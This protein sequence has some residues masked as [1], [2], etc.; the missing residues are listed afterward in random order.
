MVKKVI[1][2]IFFL[3]P[4]LFL[5]S[6]SLQCF[7]HWRW[8]NLLYKQKKLCTFFFV[9]LK[10]KKKKGTRAFS[11]SNFTDSML[12]ADMAVAGS[13]GAPRSRSSC[14][15]SALLSSN[16]HFITFGC[17][18]ISKLWIYLRTEYER[19]GEFSR[20][21]FID[22]WN[23]TNIFCEKILEEIVGQGMKRGTP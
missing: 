9:Y 1:N 22:T 18:Y 6:L 20:I 15:K 23:S 3:P 10:K 16:E 4:T 19:K 13:K 11:W 2:M 17:K 14:S 8:I 12:L 7:Y 21:N 5:Q